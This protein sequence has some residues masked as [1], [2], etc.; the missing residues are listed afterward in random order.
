MIGKPPP[1]LTGPARKRDLVELRIA[2]LRR[3]LEAETDPCTQA[4]ILYEMGTLC[5]HELQSLPDAMGHYARAHAAERRFQP[6]RIA[7]LRIA[8]R[9]RSRH[10]IAALCSDQVAASHGSAVRAAALVDLALC[11]KDWASL[12]REAIACSPEPVVPALVLEWLA[13]AHGDENALRDA[14][15]A[16]AA[17]TS[18]PSLRAALWIDVALSELDR[19]EIDEALSAL[20]RASH[21]DLLAWASRSLQ[22]DIARRH[23]RLDVLVHAATSMARMLENAVAHGEPSDPLS[24][25]V[26]MDERLPMAAL[27]W[28]EAAT[29]CAAEPGDPEAAA[30]YLESAIRLAPRDRTA[31]LQALLLAESCKDEGAFDQARAW[32][33]ETAPDDPAFVAHQV[34]HALSRDEHHQAIETLREVAARHPGSEYVRAAL[35]VALVRGKA[36]AERAQRL[37]ENAE[38]L[39]GEA[40]AHLLWHAAQLGY[41]RDD[42]QPA[43]SLFEEAA[44]EATRSKRAILREGLGG[45][46]HGRDPG[47]IL[48]RCDDLLD[49]DIEPPERVLLAF[50]KYD[51][52]QNVLG[53]GQEARQLLREALGDEV[54]DGWAPPV[55]RVR[56]AEADDLGLLGEA[57]ERLA[58]LT[59]GDARIQHL[60]AAG[61]AYARSRD[62]S[63]A[64]RALRQAFRAAPNDRYVLS[65]LE[66]VLRE[67]GRPEDVVALARARAG[68]KPVAVLGERSLLLAGAAAERHGNLTAAR[69]A[70][71]QALGGEQGSPSAALALADVA[72]R[73]RDSEA[74]MHAYAGLADAKLGGGVSELFALLW[75][76]ALGF[77][78]GP[79]EDASK[80]YERS[81]DHQASALSGAVALLSMPLELTTDDQRSAAEEI[82]SDAETPLSQ[83][84]NG[85]GA[86]YGALRAALGAEESSAGDAWLQLAGLAPTETLRA[87]TLLQGLRDTHVARGEEAIDDLFMLAQGAID[88]AEVSPEGAIAIDEALT[89]GD[90]PELRVA[91]LERK[92]RHSALLGRGALE[93]AYCRALVEADRGAEAIDLLSKALDRRPDDVALWEALHGAARQAGEWPLVA[94]ACERLAPFVEGSLKADLL[95]EAGVVRLDHMGQRQQAEDL[96]RRALG[97]DPTRT[98]AFRRLHDLLAE[99]GDA[100]S[101]EA[102]VSER[103][104]LGGH[105]ERADLLYERAR[106][107]RGFSDRP[108]ALEA[109]DEL[110]TTEPT[111]VGALALAAEVHVSLE[112]WN[113][114]VECLRRLSRSEIPEEQRRV[115]HL[116]AA[117]FLETR[118][119]A[120]D[121]ALAE[122][123]AIETLGLCDAETWARIGKL[124]AGLENDTASIEAYRRALETDPTHAGAIAGLADVLDGADKDAVIARYEDAIWE[125]IEDGRL[126]ESLLEGLGNAAAWRGQAKRA[127]AVRATMQALG[128]A[129]ADGTGTPVPLA[130]VPTTAIQDPDA[131]P[132]LVEALRRAGPALWD[133]RVRAKKA[134]PSDPIY[135]EIESLSERFGAHAKSIGLSDE[136]TTVIARTDGGA[137]IDW[138]VPGRA[139]AGLDGKGRFAAGRLAW[140]APRGAL[141]LLD[142]TPQR[143]AGTLAAILRAARCEV[144]PGD[145][146][147]PAVEVK[148]RRAVRKGVHEAVG[149]AKLEPSMLL[150]FARSMQR[151]A[152]RA[153]LLASGDIAAAF[154]KLLAGGNTLTALKASAR[155]LDL[156]RFWIGADSPLWGDDG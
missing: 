35:D 153:G 60:C 54:N 11:S 2:N 91:A 33:R 12:L 117:D 24:L 36:F 34:R 52:I 23:G 59:S 145:P 154:A 106:L 27:L 124:E 8:E 118:L 15:R 83:A 57:H 74:M 151:S 53:N 7:E 17:N 142:Q 112:Q 65:L 46:L 99:Q 131:S 13:E 127:L 98:V 50:S 42:G 78:A 87:A 119:G 82:L 133:G 41:K 31:R 111:H 76:D 105:T 104:A 100:E 86:A 134:T 122:L 16:Q 137:D 3:E 6:S 126:D 121:Q 62:W 18:E 139:R 113:E 43:R 140:A 141:W 9:T 72:R 96:F 61:Q 150:A 125:R 107:L 30:R 85:F 68:E 51:V 84:S 71:E 26:P 93:A 120:K 22:R 28:Q 135:A 90:D 44:A 148:L 115:A 80:A 146:V 94:Q 102:L 1:T 47:S 152:D 123:R 5:E 70:Y 110:F 10:D 25:S 55:A 66:R 79:A 38:A 56:A 81:L 67:G 108:G 89:P 37:C 73:Q 64:E 40:R 20:D 128:L 130:P 63:A 29:L 97:E 48:A 69:D 49:C 45:A 129:A 4:A 155:G 147:L 136:V 88:L 138:V 95:E 77:A 19:G 101:L 116:G 143:V 39:E 114:A 32:F 14:L 58:S 103:L 149:G 92:L 75:G 21:S 144:S 156:L 132:I 109:L